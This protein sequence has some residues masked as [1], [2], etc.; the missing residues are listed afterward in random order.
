M[1]SRHFHNASFSIPFRFVAACNIA[2]PHVEL[3][4]DEVH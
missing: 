4:V 3:G 1:Y 2:A